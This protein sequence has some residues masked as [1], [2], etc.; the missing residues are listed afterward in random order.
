MHIH[1]YITGVHKSKFSI[2]HT[3]CIMDGSS[4]NDLEKNKPSTST[5][6]PVKQFFFFLTLER[7]KK[8]ECHIDKP[9]LQEASKPK[10]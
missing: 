3:S 9:M 7:E 2:S 4:N 5:M 8:K 1:G 6:E 10:Y